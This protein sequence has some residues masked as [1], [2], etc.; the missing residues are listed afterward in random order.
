M[1]KNKLKNWFLNFLILCV[2]VLNMRIGRASYSLLQPLKSQPVKSNLMRVPT[3]AK[4]NDAV[5]VRTESPKR[6]LVH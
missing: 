4:Y 5:I 6:M 3:R 1:Y 2:I